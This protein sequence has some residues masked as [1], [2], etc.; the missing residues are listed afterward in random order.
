MVV[1]AADLCR[2]GASHA[3]LYHN[4]Y[5]T[6]LL[7]YLV[8]R[9]LGTVILF[10]EKFYFL[11]YILCIIIDVLNSLLLPKITDWNRIIIKHR[12]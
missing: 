7:A 6:T 12:I 11:F 2:V 10:L 5:H 4:R 9:S 3:T 8:N 1:I